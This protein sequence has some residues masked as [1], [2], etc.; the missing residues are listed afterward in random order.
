M[1]L[2]PCA[3]NSHLN[4]IACARAH[5]HTYG[6]EFSILLENECGKLGSAGL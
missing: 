1:L 3:V 5:T 4:V 6:N 2:M